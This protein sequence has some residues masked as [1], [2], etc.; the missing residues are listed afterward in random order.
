MVIVLYPM[1]VA[2]LLSYINEKKAGGSILPSWILHGVLNS[3][4]GILQAML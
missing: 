2:V 4:S 3:L 1:V